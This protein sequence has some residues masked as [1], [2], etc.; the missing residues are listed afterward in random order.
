MKRVKK[1]I[2]SCGLKP[3]KHLAAIDVVIRKGD[4][5]VVSANYGSVCLCVREDGTI[6]VCIYKGFNFEVKSVADGL[7]KM[8]ML[9]YILWIDFP[10][11]LKT[12]FYFL[13]ALHGETDKTISPTMNKLRKSLL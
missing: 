6:F 11:T 7:N 8:L 3:G 12:F 10:S 4:P 2:N 5:A 13:A 1:V 9:F